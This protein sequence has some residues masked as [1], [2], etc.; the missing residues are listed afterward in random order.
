MGAAKASGGGRE[1]RV[2]R[3]GSGPTRIGTPQSKVL[4]LSE[5]NCAPN[6]LSV[7]I[8]TKRFRSSRPGR[9]GHQFNDDNAF[10][11]VK[12][13]TALPCFV[14]QG[15]IVMRIDEANTIG[16]KCSEQTDHSK[17]LGRWSRANPPSRQAHPHETVAGRRLAE[18]RLRARSA[19]PPGPPR[20]PRRRTPR[21]RGPR[22]PPA[23]G[24][25][26]R[27]PW[28]TARARAGAGRGRW[29]ADGL[30]NHGEVAVAHRQIEAARR[31]AP[32]STCPRTGTARPRPAAARHSSA[33]SGATIRPQ[34]N[35]AAVRAARRQRQQTVSASLHRGNMGTGAASGSHKGIQA[36]CVPLAVHAKPTLT[37]RN[38]Q[39]ILN[40]GSKYSKLSGARQ[41]TMN[42]IC[43]RTITDIPF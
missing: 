5:L 41:G 19:H 27:P 10:C 2:L 29:R 16:Q 40:V 25:A 6:P 14:S 28:R 34:R 42:N 35:G 33:A 22:A 15:I 11:R 13:R 9:P 18:Q 36:L 17:I 26:P 12:D 39:N 7:Q 23:G 4:Y 43:N 1:R 3:V 31:R 38:L 30:G 8:A 37:L 20:A 24:S 32:P 21:R